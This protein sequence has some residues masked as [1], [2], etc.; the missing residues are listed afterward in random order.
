M[1]VLFFSQSAGSP[2]ITQR[3]VLTE[4]MGGGGRGLF[5]LRSRSMGVAFG[6]R[7]SRAP[8]Q[9]N[10]H[11]AVTPTDPGFVWS[12]VLELFAAWMQRRRS[13]RERKRG[14]ALSSV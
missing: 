12:P 2:H 9:N 3:R 13:A 10:L 8:W 7:D 1:T 6:T 4:S 5:F 14:V 11:A